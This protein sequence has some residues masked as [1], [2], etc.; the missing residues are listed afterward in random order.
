MLVS[1]NSGYVLYI[2]TLFLHS[3]MISFSVLIF[4]YSDAGV[5]VIVR[6][7]VVMAP[8]ILEKFSEPQHIEYT[9]TDGATAYGILD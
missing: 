2:L 8:E 7:G 3:V 6:S 9:T 1:V 5:K 4:Y